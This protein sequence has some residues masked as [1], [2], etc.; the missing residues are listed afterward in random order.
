MRGFGTPLLILTIVAIAA[1]VFLRTRSVDGQQNF[2]ESNRRPACTI[3]CGDGTMNYIVLAKPPQCWGGPLPADNADEHYKELPKE[4]RNVICQNLKPGKPSD[5]S[6]PAFKALMATCGAAGPEKGGKETPKC[7]PPTPWFGDAAGCKD[8][9]APKAVIGKG[10][11]SLSI[12]GLTVFTEPFL[13]DD[14]LGMTAYAEVLKGE[15]EGKIGTRICCDSLRQASRTGIPCDPV[16][17]FDCDGK[18]NAFDT[19][20]VGNIRY[21]DIDFF[22]SGSG[23]TIDELPFGLNPSDPGFMPPSDKCDCKW[24]MMKGTLTCS[25][26]GRQPHVYEA[27][28]RCPSTGN[29]RFTRK[30]AAAAERCTA[31]TGTRASLFEPAEELATAET[32]FYWRKRLHQRR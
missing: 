21:P 30:T 13:P 4:A 20:N 1:F 27:R 16:K 24:E 22:T 11:V 23:S 28:W 10:G 9:Q 26:D 7:E 32:L 31:P 29:Q 17:D 14:S 12:C 25:P 3:F 6:C 5:A 8:V 18:L 19:Y 15:V 2:P